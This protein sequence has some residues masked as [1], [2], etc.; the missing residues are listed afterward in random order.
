MLS[1]LLLGDG[2]MRK[3]DLV[4]LPDAFLAVDADICV[5]AC[6]ILV[7]GVGQLEGAHGIGAHAVPEKIENVG[8]SFLS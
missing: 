1:H 3:P 6:V 7:A 8:Y 5:K 2:E 4:L